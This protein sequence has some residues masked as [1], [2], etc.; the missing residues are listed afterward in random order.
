MPVAAACVMLATRRSS[1][2][3]EE[4]AHGERERKMK[5]SRVVVLTAQL[6][7]QI[8]CHLNTTSP[9]QAIHTDTH[10]HTGF[11]MFG[12]SLPEVQDK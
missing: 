10:T 5:R 4:Q 2:R 9:V 8:C 1:T 6:M 11:I 12:P 7:F 3:T